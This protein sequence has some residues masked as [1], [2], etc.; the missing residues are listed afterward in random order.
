MSDFAFDLSQAETALAVANTPEFLE[1]K[2]RSDPAVKDLLLRYG[3]EELRRKLSAVLR[4]KPKNLSEAVQPYAFLVA[5]SFDADKRPLLSAMQLK[6]KYHDWYGD[7]VR[8]LKRNVAS[9][10]FVSVPPAV[11]PVRMTLS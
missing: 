10:S 9:N 8:I 5:M 2:L 11:H 1:R 3:G 7:F 4:R 6:S